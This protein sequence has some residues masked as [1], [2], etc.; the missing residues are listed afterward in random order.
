MECRDL[1]S[2]NVVRT[3]TAFQPSAQGCAKGATLGGAVRHFTTLKGLNPW[4]KPEP[5][6]PLQGW[7]KFMQLTQG[8]RSFLAPTLGWKM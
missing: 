6:Q 3:P 2:S 8:R 4:A 7:R 5:M 1:S